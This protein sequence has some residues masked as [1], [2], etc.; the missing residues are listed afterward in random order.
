[1]GLLVFFLWVIFKQRVYQTGTDYVVQLR[2]HTVKLCHAQSQDLF[3]KVATNTKI[4]LQEA[5]RQKGGRII[6]QR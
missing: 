6:D 5:E 4:R 1:M 2:A 3:R